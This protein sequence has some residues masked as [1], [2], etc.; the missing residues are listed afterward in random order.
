MWKKRQSNSG[1]MFC[2]CQ[3]VP[4]PSCASGRI[5]IN[6]RSNGFESRASERLTRIKDVACRGIRLPFKP[7]T[8]EAGWLQHLKGSAIK[9]ALTS[10]REVPAQV[11]FLT[12]AVSFQQNKAGDDKNEYVMSPCALM[13]QDR[14]DTARTAISAWNC[15]SS[16]R[17]HK[18]HYIQCQNGNK[19]EMC[20]G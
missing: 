7:V 11:M 16:I 8:D 19:I 18:P 2:W 9:W 4:T 15:A 1:Q 5:L 17:E 6:G 13:A 12:S 20:S 14:L 3:Q 10:W